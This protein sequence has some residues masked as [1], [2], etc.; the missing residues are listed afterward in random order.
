VIAF[1]WAAAVVSVLLV[2]LGT[3]VCVRKLRALVAIGDRLSKHPLFV[4]FATAEASSDT[5]GRA[6]QH[7]TDSLQK[8]GDG[9]RAVSEALGA[10]AAF[11]EFVNV[12]AKSVE[13]LLEVF[14]PTLRGHPATK[15]I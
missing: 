2:A 7:M 1:F 10:I 12:I 5:I 3:I 6:A 4:T 8:L 13:E 11:A 15:Q 9:V 14:V